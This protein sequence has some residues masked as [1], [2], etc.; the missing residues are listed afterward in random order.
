MSQTPSPRYNRPFLPFLLLVLALA[1]VIIGLKYTDDASLPAAAPSGSKADAALPI[2]V[3]DT[4]TDPTIALPAADTTYA[5]LADTLLGKDR[6]NPYEAGYEDGYAAGC[7]D[8]AADTREATYDESS[9]FASQHERADY[10][11]GY[12][13]GYPVGYEDG[14]KGLQFN[15]S[16]T[17]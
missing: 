17:H 16:A 5:A 13:E 9:G 7:D 1:A 10:V 6:R 11:R 12:R 2:A 4:T 3:P 15:I 14:Q 8:G